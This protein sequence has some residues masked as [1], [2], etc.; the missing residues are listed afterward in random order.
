MGIP[1]TPFGRVWADVRYRS[2]QQDTGTAQIQQGSLSLKKQ[3]V[4]N[5]FIKSSH[6]LAIRC[7]CKVFISPARTPVAITKFIWGRQS[8]SRWCHPAFRGPAF[9]TSEYSEDHFLG[10][11]QML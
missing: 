8:D 7:R 3:T 4:N 11:S 9:K 5:H 10:S 6:R 1:Q 2:K